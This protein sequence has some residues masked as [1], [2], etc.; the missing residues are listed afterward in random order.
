MVLVDEYDRAP[1]VALST[2]KDMHDT[3]AYDQAVALLHSFLGTLKDLGGWDGKSLLCNWDHQWVSQF[4]MMQQGLQLHVC[5]V[6]GKI[7]SVKPYVPCKDTYERSGE[8][9][10]STVLLEDITQGFSLVCFP[11]SLYGECCKKAKSMEHY[12]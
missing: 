10:N 7:W 9:L 1:L 4:G 3:E 5:R 8:V 11:L 12:E 6:G 2:G